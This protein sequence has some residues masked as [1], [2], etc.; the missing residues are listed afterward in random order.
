M[1]KLGA[2]VT[3]AIL[4][5]KKEYIFPSGELNLQNFRKWLLQLLIQTKQF[6]DNDAL[7]FVREILHGPI[8]NAN[9]FSHTARFLNANREF[10]PQDLYYFRSSL[11]PTG[12]YQ[13]YPEKFGTKRAEHISEFTTSKQQQLL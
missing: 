4:K 9:T 7:D 6:K 8:G 11:D 5:K 3:H 1:Q 12:Q 2:R 10:S 13:W